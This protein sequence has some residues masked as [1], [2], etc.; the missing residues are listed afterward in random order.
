MSKTF[1]TEE[2]RKQS[3]M[4][5]GIVLIILIIGVAFY[6]TNLP[7]KTLIFQNNTN[8]TVSKDKA[9]KTVIVEG[10]FKVKYVKSELYKE[11][12]IEKNIDSDGKKIMDIVF[13]ADKS[14]LTL[15]T[16]SVKPDYEFKDRVQ[17]FP[18]NITKP[19]KIEG[20]SNPN[21]AFIPEMNIKGQ[22]RIVDTKSKIGDTYIKQITFLPMYGRSDMV[23]NEIYANVPTEYV[24]TNKV[25]EFLK[26]ITIE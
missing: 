11:H 6:V 9:D 23:I 10:V 25:I 1:K 24:D 3:T 17:T 13:I 2:Q 7:V 20:L 18:E 5:I 21:F 22:S 26:N 15:S 14:T 8:S 12:R 4:M 16:I 19:E